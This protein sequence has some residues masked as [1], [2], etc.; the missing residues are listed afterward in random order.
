M[1][2]KEDEK[3]KLDGEHKEFVINKLALHC[4]QTEIAEAVKVEFDIDIT[5]QC[6]DYYK[7]EYEK[8]WRKRREYLNKHI[9]EIEPFA[10]KALRVKERGNLIRD[11]IENDDLWQLDVAVKCKQIVRDNK[12]NPVLLKTRANHLVVNMLLDSIHKELEPGKL[13]L[14]DPTGSE[15]FTGIIVLPEKDGKNGGKGNG[16][17]SK[18]K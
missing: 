4:G 8:E 15:P 5:K 17:K 18:A 10:D 12:N 1:A 13:A 14:T 9:A 16:R 11:I 2:K 6:V 7:R 3:F